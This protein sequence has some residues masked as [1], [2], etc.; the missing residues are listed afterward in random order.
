MVHNG[1]HLPIAFAISSAASDQVSRM[2]GAVRKE[3]VQGKISLTKLRP[4]AGQQSQ[5]IAFTGGSGELGVENQ[6]LNG[7]GMNLVA[8][9]EY[10]GFVVARSAQPT[11][12]CVAL[13]SK[14]GSHVYA[15]QALKVEPGDWKRLEFKLTPSAGDSAG[16]FAV[17]LKR[18]ATVTVGYA[19]LEPGPWGRYKGLP[20]R[21]DIVEEMLANGV[22]AVRF[23]ATLAWAHEYRW[24]MGAGPRERRS[25]FPHIFYPFSSGGWSYLDLLDLCDTAGLW[26]IPDFAIT[27]KPEDLLDFIEYANGA[28][29]TPW[30]RRRIENG[31]PQPFQIRHIQVGNE[32]RLH[33][34]NGSEEYLQRFRPLAEAIWSKY[35]EMILIVGDWTGITSENHLT[36]P[37]YRELLQIARDFNAEI[38]FDHHLETEH[39]DDLKGASH[40]AAVIQT[41]QKLADGAKFKVVVLELNSVSH[42]DMNRALANAE[43]LGGL[44]KL[45]DWIPLVCS[46]NALQ[47]D[48]QH[49]NGWD[50]GAVFFDPAKAWTQPP[51]FVSR[52]ISDS[53]LPLRAKTEVIG[54]EKTLYATAETDD[55]R[56]KITLRVVNVAEEWVT[57]QVRITGF[58]PA[59]P[60]AEVTTLAGEPDASNTASHP[61][62]VV[63][64]RST[65]RHGLEDSTTTYTFPPHSFTILRFQ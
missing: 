41:L 25:P 43:T 15:E 42:H 3:N 11:L 44:E 29:D 4:L 36:A 13:E 56:R 50:Q 51:G 62:R 6:G 55:G 34:K 9:R 38:W 59:K 61:D 7:W 18:A 20:V 32:E 21:A 26:P 16:R 10:E 65:W 28:P 45:G 58:R 31:H 57:T 14:D 40:T 17:K 60:D 33:L 24:K 49:D 12:L 64:R 53:R 39:P 19:F 5:Q 37:L 2:W 27:E 23:S 54:A 35:P 1:K 52:M 22:S 47:A 8:G 46:S 30:G 48:G 63:P